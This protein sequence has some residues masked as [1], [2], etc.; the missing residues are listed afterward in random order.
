MWK[1]TPLSVYRVKYFC[2]RGVIYVAECTMSMN[3]NRLSQQL[4]YSRTG[5]R[6]DKEM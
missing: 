2:L 5:I 3:R 1:N 6:L 4:V